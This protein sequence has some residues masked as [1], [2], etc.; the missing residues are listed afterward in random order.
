MANRRPAQFDFPKRKTIEKMAGQTQAPAESAPDPRPA[1]PPPDGWWDAVLGDPR[2]RAKQRPIEDMRLTDIRQ[3]VLRV[4][5][6]RCFRIVEIQR[7]DAIRLYGPGSVWGSV[8]EHLLETGC[9]HRTGNRDEDGCWAS[10]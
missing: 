6:L 2:A 5:C 1:G 10:R 4:E 8:R 3:E 7:L 9:D